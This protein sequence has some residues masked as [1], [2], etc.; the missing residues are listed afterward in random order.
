MKTRKHNFIILFIVATFFILTPLLTA[1]ANEAMQ[2][3]NTKVKTYKL[4]VDGMTCPFCVYGIEKRLKKIDGVLN[5]DSD[6]DK[7]TIII[8]AKEKAIVTKAIAKKEITAAGFT[9]KKFEVS[10][11]PI[12]KNTK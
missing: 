9:L 12:S 7:G 2:Q 3:L 1:H 5:I 6:L 10:S 4:T 11:K 8:H